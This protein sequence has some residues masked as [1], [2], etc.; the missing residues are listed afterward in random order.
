MSSWGASAQVVVAQVKWTAMYR[1]CVLSE[2]IGSDMAMDSRRAGR[3]AGR[4]CPSYVDQKR[5]LQ[6]AHY[7]LTQAHI[8]CRVVAALVVRLEG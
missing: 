1:T 4:G 3:T 6:T 2:G 7:T 8:A 5:L